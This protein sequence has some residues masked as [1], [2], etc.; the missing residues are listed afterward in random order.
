LSALTPSESGPRPILP[1]NTLK[2]LYLL[3]E[4][5]RRDFQVRFTGSA[6]GIFWAV[7]QPLS[8]VILYWFVFTFMIQRAPVPGMPNFALFLISGLVP[9]IGF[10]EAIIRGTTA[11]VDN[12]AM[13]R[14]L[15]LRS[16][17]LVLVPG[18]TALIFEA[19]ALAL[20]V[21]FLIAR[22]LTLQGLWILPFALLLQLVL[23]TGVAWFLASV[24]VVFRD[25][26]QVLGFVLSI[27]FYLSP[28]L[29]PVE[30]P[31]EKFF[32]W[33]P[34]T[35]LL[36]L[37]RS[38]ILGLPLPEPGSLVFLLI[39]SMALLFGGLWV[40]RRARPTLIDLI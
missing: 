30:G 8:L 4:L 1:A 6:L 9:W 28:I 10:S 16:E 35:P 33:N 12:A 24:F 39:V 14:R 36:G 22:G 21:G 38:A 34:L 23:Q 40:F 3:R 37:F 18:I 5:V 32:M 26:M 13:V 20:F 11:L 31:F 2:D 29:Y 19:I 25:V 7:L 15:A 27:V 17:L